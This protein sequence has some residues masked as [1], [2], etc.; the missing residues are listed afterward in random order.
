VEEKLQLV[1][2]LKAVKFLHPL[3]EEALAF[4][5]FLEVLAFRPFLEVLAFRPFLEVLALLLELVQGG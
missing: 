1:D 4:R 2:L 3:A 5:P